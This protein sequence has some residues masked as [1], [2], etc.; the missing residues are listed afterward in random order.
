MRRFIVL[1]VLSLLAT[2]AVAGSK[3]TGKTTLKDVQPAG[4]PEKKEKQQYDLS[5][6]STTN[7]EYVCRTSE[8]KDFKAT[9][10]VVG[11]GVSY[12]VKDNKGKLKAADGKKVECTIVRVANAPAAPK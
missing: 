5:F 7:K 6:V 3:D 1:A 10:F 8:K 12:E 11:E 9:D 2:N 4:T